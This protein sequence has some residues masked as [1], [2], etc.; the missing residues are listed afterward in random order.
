[1]I[2]PQEKHLYKL[3]KLHI[4][5]QRRR[6]QWKQHPRKGEVKGEEKDHGG[7]PECHTSV[8]GCYSEELQVKQSV[9]NA[10]SWVEATK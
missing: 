1:M 10:A 5:D 7:P 4:P 6:Q 9:Q 8:F 3:W 2:R